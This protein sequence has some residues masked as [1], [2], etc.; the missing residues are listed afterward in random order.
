MTARFKPI[1]LAAA[2]LC[3]SSTPAF[4]QSSVSRY[5]LI[6]VSAGRFQ[7]A[8]AVKTNRVD[9]GNMA[10]SYFGFSGKEDLGGGMKAKFAIESFLRADTG[11]Q[12]RFGG[13]VYWTRAA[14]VGLEGG[15]GST[16]LGR[17]TNQFFVSTLIFNAFGD[18]FGY[19]PSIRQVLVPSGPLKFLG[20]TGWSNS[21]LYS[22]PSVGGFSVNLQG[23]LGEKAASTTGNSAGA[24]VLYFGGPFAATLAYQ[25]A[26][27]GLNGGTPVAS[28]TSSRPRSVRRMTSPP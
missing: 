17:T 15:F 6:D 28:R 20:D 10:T 12:G 27:H 16:T 11:E 26:K 8:G 9:S 14:W 4:A 13:D 3:L 23:A 18:A 7:D 22:S 24:N 5:G 1:V 2:T 19:S 21:L 25:Q